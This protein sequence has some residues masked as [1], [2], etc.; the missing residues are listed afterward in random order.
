[1]GT[2]RYYAW[3]ILPLL[4]ILLLVTFSTVALAELV[5]EFPDPGLEAAI[6]EA[7][8][9]PTGDICDSDL[10]GLTTRICPGWSI[11]AT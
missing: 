10:V 6:W 2:H 3:C 11:A 7:I 9:K 8:S 4:S 1:M 5:V